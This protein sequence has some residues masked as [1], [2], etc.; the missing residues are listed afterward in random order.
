MPI[1]KTA[2]KEVS[3]QL[4]KGKK[5]PRRRARRRANTEDFMNIEF[6]LRAR[7]KTPDEREKLA[8]EMGFD[9][10]SAKAVRTKKARHSLPKASDPG[11]AIKRPKADPKNIA[12]LRGAAK[13]AKASKPKKATEKKPQP[14]KLQKLQREYDGLLPK[15]KNAER[16]KG[17]NSKYAP[18]F[19]ARGMTDMTEMKAGG[20]VKRKGGGKVYKYG[21]GGGL[22]KTKGKKVS[23]NDGNAIVAACYD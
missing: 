11:I 23:G 1:L 15:V 2:A 14:T 9:K 17:N 18:V 19:K 7:G 5:K 10:E 3:K 20:M 22:G 16:Q 8:I 6:D 13:K 4:T 12:T 21:H